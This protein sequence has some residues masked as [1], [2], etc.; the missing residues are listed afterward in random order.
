MNRNNDRTLNVI[1]VLL[2]VLI[3]L[4]LFMDIKDVVLHQV[5]ANDHIPFFM[6]AVLSI[7]V[8][9]IHKMKNI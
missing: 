9:F 8:V 3:G 4:Y 7:F 2:I 6:P 5:N 1:S